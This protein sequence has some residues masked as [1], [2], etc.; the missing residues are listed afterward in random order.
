[1]DDGETSAAVRHLRADPTPTL[2]GTLDIV[3]RAAVDGASV[4]VNAFDQYVPGF[5]VTFL[6]IGMMLGISLTLFDERDWGTLQRV[7]AGGASLAGILIGKVLARVVIGVAQMIVLFGVGWALFDIALGRQP[8]ALLLPMISMSFAGAAL[9][10][11]IPTL[12][13]AHDSVMPLGTMTSLALAAV[14]GCWWPLDFE[15]AWMRT[16]AHWLP[17]T[18]TMQAYNDLMIRGAPPSAA[19]VPFLY[20]MTLGCG[21]LV[22][23][24]AAGMARQD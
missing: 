23:G 1:V 18:W 10:L 21:L 13:P 3:E 16:I 20:T 8:A 19:V 2:P 22:I 12:A 17:T 5:G 14:G 11:V 4:R 15:P 24:V 6:L 7:R 9:G